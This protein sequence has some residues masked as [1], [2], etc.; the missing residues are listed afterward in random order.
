MNKEEAGKKVVESYFKLVKEGHYEPYDEKGFYDALTL[1]K[2]KGVS[3]DTIFDEIMMLED[4]RVDHRFQT[5]V[6]KAVL[7]FSRKHLYYLFANYASFNEETEKI[8]SKKDLAA[9]IYKRADE[10][11]KVK[12]EI[13][14]IKKQNFIIFYLNF[15]IKE[16]NEKRLKEVDEYAFK[17]LFDLPSIYNLFI[18]K[19]YL[20][21]NEMDK[22]DEYK[23]REEVKKNDAYYLVYEIF[24]CV[25]KKDFEKAYETAEKLRFYN[26]YLAYLFIY[27]N[28]TLPREYYIKAFPPVDD[29]LYNLTCPMTEQNKR[30]FDFE[31]MCLFFI[32]HLYNIIN[33]SG[34]REYADDRAAKEFGIDTQLFNVLVSSAYYHVTTV[35]DSA[36]DA[37]VPDFLLPLDNMVY[38]M[39]GTKSKTKAIYRDSPF[40]GIYKDEKTDD[41]FGLFHCLENEGYITI[42]HDDEY[43]DFYYFTL[44]GQTAYMVATYILGEEKFDY[45]KDVD[46]T[47]LELLH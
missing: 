29:N 44:R 45:I 41:I 39:K 34:F 12:R 32:D 21:N 33:E 7:K 23:E 10:A 16:K 37:F 24:S 46:D 6:F 14:H 19:Y 27:E 38:F 17:K 30:L 42:I 28:R 8:I 36:P 22:F 4:Y 5:L 1:F 25:Y 31:F 9:L 11:I 26:L 20:C 40:F 43:N 18:M 2:E 13:V 47:E 15:L 35:G 3:Y